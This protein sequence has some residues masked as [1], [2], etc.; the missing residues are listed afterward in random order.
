MP[1]YYHGSAPIVDKISVFSSESSNPSSYNRRRGP[2]FSVL[3]QLHLNDGTQYALRPCVPLCRHE[4]VVSSA[5]WSRCKKKC[6]RLHSAQLSLPEP[7]HLT[8]QSKAHFQACTRAYLAP[9]DQRRSPDLTIDPTTAI[10]RGR[11]PAGGTSKHRTAQIQSA[12]N[13][14]LNISKPKR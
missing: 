13:A 8:G 2:V 3:V 1:A 7:N 14:Y 12:R 10:S 11:R 5:D 9:P 4:W 6:E